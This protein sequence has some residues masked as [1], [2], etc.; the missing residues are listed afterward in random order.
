MAD[1]LEK[2]FVHFDV[3]LN[4]QVV[5]IEMLPLPRGD[6]QEFSDRH[7][8]LFE[9]MNGIRID[10]RVRVVVISGVEGGEVFWTPEL[11]T[12]KGSADIE[13]PPNVWKAS[14]GIV[15][16]HEAMADLDRPIIAKV[17]GDAI[18]WGSSVVFSCDLIVARE[19]ARIADH[20]MGMGE[21]KPYRV[22]A[23]VV[24]GDGGVALMP[25][26]MSPALA[27]EYLMLAREYTGRELADLGII[28]AAVPADHLDEKVEQMVKSLLKRS[29]YALAWT[30]RIA[31]KHINAQ[32]QMRLDAS[33]AY[34]L[35]NI[36]QLSRYGD[37]T[38]L[39]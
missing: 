17:N 2:K 21:V 20:H 29:A 25:L 4:D 3:E 8:E 28:N 16:V 7:W 10:N 13:S 19:D 38:S 30:K 39:E 23:G 36:Y 34:E 1:Y 24:P 9:I 6:S 31:N 12:E 37:T 33:V 14:T 15:R 26:F 35:L 11:L 27:K 32:L 18:G 22:A 5:R